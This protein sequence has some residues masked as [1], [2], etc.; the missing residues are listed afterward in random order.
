MRTAREKR[1]G[2]GAAGCKARG[3][4]AALRTDSQEKMEWH[5]LKGQGQGT[6]NW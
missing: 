1:G 4:P 6:E 3:F 5:S 2:R